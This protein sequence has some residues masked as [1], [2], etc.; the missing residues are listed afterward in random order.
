MTEIYVNGVIK[1]GTWRARSC[2]SCVCPFTMGGRM[3]E[4]EKSTDETLSVTWRMALVRT[5]LVK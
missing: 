5:C 4:A 1:I 3:V 2:G